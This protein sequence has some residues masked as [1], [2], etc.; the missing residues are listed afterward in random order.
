MKRIRSRPIAIPGDTRFKTLRDM[1]TTKKDDMGPQKAP[2]RGR[3]NLC[4][5]DSRGQKGILPS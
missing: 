3:Q 1:S 2:F 4:R 5:K